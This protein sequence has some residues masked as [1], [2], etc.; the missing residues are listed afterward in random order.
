MNT[1]MRN[2]FMSG[3]GVDPAVLKTTLTLIVVAVCL[4]VGTW[5]VLQ[6]I[7]AY[8]NEDITSSEVT[9][10]CVKLIVLLCLVFYVVI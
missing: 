6:L 9:L 3:S 7:D 5:V 1:Q 8:R 10:G 2:A 4:T